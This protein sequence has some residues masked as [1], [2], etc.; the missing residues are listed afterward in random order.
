LLQAAWL[1]IDIVTVVATIDERGPA[2]FDMANRGNDDL[3][4]Q[5]AVRHSR[6]VRVL[7]ILVPIIIVVGIA[8]G[9]GYHLLNKPLRALATLPGDIGNL[10]VSGTKSTMQHPRIAGFTSDRRGS[11]LTAQAAARDLLTPDVIE[12]QGLHATLEMQNNVSFKT[13]AH[14]GFYD[15]KSE[16]LTL[17]DNILVTTTS[18]YQAKMTQAVIDIR[19]GK[20]V[21]EKPVEVKSHEWLVKSNRMEV[22]DSGDV[23]RFDRGVSVTIEGESANAIRFDAA[24]RPR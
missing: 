16:L 5:A 18:G 22:S 2:V 15:T 14:S 13:T 4:F 19:A 3:L 17:E 11:E 1:G 21:S 8:G 20:I 7:R 23:V 12:L 10:G 6:Y 24:V 9:A